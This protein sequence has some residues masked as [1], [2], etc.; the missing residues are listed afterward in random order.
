MLT[1]PGRG[2]CHACTV[3]N[4]HSHTM[5]N[6]HGCQRMCHI[7]GRAAIVHGRI[8]MPATEGVLTYAREAIDL[9]CDL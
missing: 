1:G 8:D 5:Y 7:L 4:S 9:G 3:T 2:T 6:A